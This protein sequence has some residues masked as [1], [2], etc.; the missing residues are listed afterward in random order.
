MIVGGFQP[1]S[2]VILGVFFHWVQYFIFFVP[3]SNRNLY[4]KV[5]ILKLAG[6]IEC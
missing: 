3:N 4:S 2:Q 5:N 1:T 6:V